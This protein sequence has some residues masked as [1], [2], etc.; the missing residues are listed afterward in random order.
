ML[1]YQLSYALFD[2]LSCY[3][4]A[5]LPPVYLE[6]FGYNVAFEMLHNIFL[7]TNE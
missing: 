3:C 4:F 6:Q 2:V 7:C 1:C 5:L